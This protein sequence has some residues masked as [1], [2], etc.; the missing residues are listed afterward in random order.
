MLYYRIEIGNDIIFTI[1]QSNTA[2]WAL[3]INNFPQ[4]I[5]RYRGEIG[6][7]ALRSTSTW[8]GYLNVSGLFHFRSVYAPIMCRQIID[9]LGADNQCQLIL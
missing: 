2:T 1:T 8:N 5:D 4:H 9:V 7:S 6:R 3:Y